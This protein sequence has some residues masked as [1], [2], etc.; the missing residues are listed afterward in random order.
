MIW[1]SNTNGLSM[2]RVLQKEKSYYTW[3]N[4]IFISFILLGKA[5]KEKGTIGKKKKKEKLFIKAN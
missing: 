2:D 3:K 5:E 1:A 4:I